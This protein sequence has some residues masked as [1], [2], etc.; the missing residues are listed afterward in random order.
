MGE[1][2]WN[3]AYGAISFAD[4]KEKMVVVT[5][6]VAPSKIRKAHR[7]KLTALIYGTLEK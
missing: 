6:C 5:R 1:Y 2:F 3:G 7:E 4:L